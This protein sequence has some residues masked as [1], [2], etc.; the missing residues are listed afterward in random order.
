MGKVYIGLDVGS[1]TCHL[2]A[3]TADRTVIADRKF[4]TSEANLIEAIE[5]IKGERHVHLESTELAGWIRGVLKPRVAKVVVGHAKSSAW[6]AKDPLKHDRLDATKLAD[7]LRMGMVHEVYYSDDEDRAVFKQI[8]QHYD[9]MTG[10][11]VRLKN[12][13]KARLRVQGVIVRGE[14]L[15]E[16]KSR[17]SVV[18]QVRSSA[19]R[20]AI[21][22]LGALLDDAIK[23]QGRALNLMKRQSRAYTE[24]KRF[25]EVP[26]VGIVGACRFSGYLQTPHRFSNKRKLWRYCRLG[27]TD[28]SSDGKPL[29]RQSLDINGNGRL[30]DVSCRAFLGAMRCRDDN[31][32]KRAY[33]ASLSRTNDKTHARLNVQRTILATLL[34]MWKGGTPYQDDKG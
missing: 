4:N 2:V 8:V 9:D 16:R 1:S 24:I 19:S 17:R 32:F 3:M 26:G 28:R 13:I 11:V 29:G 14:E 23:A 30:K 5:A 27:I 34:A 12:K 20:E 6:I 31:R 7:L 18:A 25:V 33:R 10:Q 22:Q 21:G 15:Y